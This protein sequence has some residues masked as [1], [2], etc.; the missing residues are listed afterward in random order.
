P[1]SSSHSHCPYTTLFRSAVLV[2]ERPR[3][4]H[5][6]HAEMGAAGESALRP[7]QQAVGARTLAPVQRDPGEVAQLLGHRPPDAL[8]LRD[9]ERSEEHTS[10]LQS[11]EKLVC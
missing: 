8:L 5:D 4:G 2:P 1:R 7:F 9:R 11:R 10:E 3:P 6:L